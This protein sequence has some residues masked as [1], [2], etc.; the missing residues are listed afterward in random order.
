MSQNN[1]VIAVLAFGALFALAKSGDKETAAV[2]E[3]RQKDIA[4]G[5]P[6]KVAVADNPLPKNKIER[7][8]LME[9]LHAALK[10]FMQINEWIEQNGKQV[11]VSGIPKNHWNRLRSLY[12]FLVELARRGNHYFSSSVSSGDDAE[13][14]RIWRGIWSGCQFLSER[15]KQGWVMNPPEQFANPTHLDDPV[16][17]VDNPQKNFNVLPKR[18]DAEMMELPE[19]L[20]L[21]QYR[22]FIQNHYI[23]Y[24]DDHSSIVNQFDNTN[25]NIFGVPSAPVT[26]R[27]SKSAFVVGNPVPTMDDIDAD[28]ANAK[29]GGAHKSKGFAPKRPQRRGRSKSPGRRDS[30]RGSRSR[31]QSPI[32]G[33][34]PVRPPH[35]PD[36][37]DAS[38][39]DEDVDPR[40]PRIGIFNPKLSQ[41]TIEGP[42]QFKAIMPPPANADVP[43]AQE[44]PLLG[45]KPDTLVLPPVDRSIQS[46][47]NQGG[48]VITTNKLQ[49]A[50]QAIEE[51]RIQG[52]TT[53]R[54]QTAVSV[55]LQ[56]SDEER[57]DEYRNRVQRSLAML[58]N[59]IRTVN[60]SAQQKGAGLEIF[61]TL[62]A[63]VPRGTGDK[64]I[65]INCYFKQRLAATTQSEDDK[66]RI[67]KTPEYRVYRNAMTKI[68]RQFQD[69]HG[70]AESK[71]QSRPEK[72]MGKQRKPAMYSKPKRTQ[73]H[74]RPGT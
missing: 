69:W 38:W 47:F 49:T 29:L 66:E 73:L 32:G 16:H 54:N 34:T 44:P 10:E 58:R 43:P 5:A 20:S 51:Q 24:V 27:R 17:G 53:A 40:S 63:A 25:T 7:R 13:F 31:S 8:R 52:D 60:P 18:S 72:L 6:K 12:D 67:R 11:Q 74:P 22:I 9:E 37:S 26:N 15:Q 3:Q 21:P 46:Q 2:K 56:M 59:V 68:Y 36:S 23:S 61:H 57:Q 62:K 71:A 42:G 1:I 35:L 45:P 14:W 28:M 48:G 50:Q 65:F 4:E 41:A 70:R 39:S 19:N 30:G 33:A 64:R 55:Q